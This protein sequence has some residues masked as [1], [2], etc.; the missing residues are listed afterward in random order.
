[1]SSL[2]PFLVDF[3]KI[4]IMSSVD[5]V[6]TIVEQG[7][8]SELHASAYFQK[9]AFAV[10]TVRTPQ[11]EQ[12][13]SAMSAMSEIE[14]ETSDLVETKSLM[15][16]EDKKVGL[17]AMHVYKAFFARMT[18][19][20]T[21]IQSIFAPSPPKEALHYWGPISLI[22]I[23]F[24]VA[25]GFKMAADFLMASFSRTH[26]PSHEYFLVRSI[27]AAVVATLAALIRSFLY[28]CACLRSSQALHNQALSHVLRA[29]VT[30]YFDVTP[31]GRTLNRF[32]K[33]TYDMDGP[34][35]SCGI[36]LLP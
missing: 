22:L 30:T 15:H 24:I 27:V 1:M 2:P 32:V 28:V 25:Q 13:L 36:L 33:D 23:L 18:W 12:H 26:L 35:L 5:S 21:R 10:P 16:V 29:P 7:T 20:S 31:V 17:V 14:V 6:C 4:V 9:L 19:S 34:L 8:Y 11:S 3:D